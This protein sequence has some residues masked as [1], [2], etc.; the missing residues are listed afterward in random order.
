MTGGSPSFFLSFMTVT[1]TVLVNGSALASQTPSSS[2]SA[3]TTRRSAA[4]SARRTPNSLFVRDSR[5][6]SRVAARRPGSSSIPRLDR[7]G[8]IDRSGRRPPQERYPSREAFP[9]ATTAAQPAFA[10]PSPQGS[11]GLTSRRGIVTGK[12]SG[13]TGP[14]RSATSPRYMAM[15]D[16]ELMSPSADLPPVPGLCLRRGG[17]P[18]GSD[19]GSPSTSSS[20]GSTPPSLCRSCARI[21]SRI[22]AAS[23]ASSSLSDFPPRSLPE[24]P[25]MDARSLMVTPPHAGTSGLTP[26]WIV[27]PDGRPG[28]AWPVTRRSLRSWQR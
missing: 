10:A 7:I 14:N 18:Y 2:S 13:T 15:A 24:L 4:S 11:V 12:V 9:P 1:R 19:S 20:S 27:Q 16:S 23:R 22:K 25:G 8:A 21:I 6:P 17:R 3:L 26:A 28:G 5:V